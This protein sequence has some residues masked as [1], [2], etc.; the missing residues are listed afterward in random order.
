MKVQYIY[1]FEIP[2]EKVAEL[3]Q[4]A[5]GI[6]CKPIEKPDRLIIANVM[7]QV[8]EQL[9]G[10]STKTVGASGPCS[11]MIQH[12]CVLGMAVMG[13]G[14]TVRFRVLPDEPEKSAPSRNIIWN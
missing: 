11:I 12:C 3:Q 8:I 13:D 14:A 2:D 6:L 4:A 1:T 7:S 9:K 5:E 10:I